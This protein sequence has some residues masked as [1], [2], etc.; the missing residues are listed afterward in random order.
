MNS[1]RILLLVSIFDSKMNFIHY[2][3][4]HSWGFLFV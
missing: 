4:P 3:A 1:G 2:Q